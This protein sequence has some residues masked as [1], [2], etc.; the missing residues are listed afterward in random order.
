MQHWAIS[1]SIL[2]SPEF[3]YQIRAKIRTSTLGMTA[4]VQA[5]TR[6]GHKLK[7]ACDIKEVVTELE[8]KSAWEVVHGWGPAIPVRTRVYPAPPRGATTDSFVIFL[9]IPAHP[10]VN[11]S[12]GAITAHF[13][14][15]H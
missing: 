1:S 6:L 14:E 9:E 12:S 5:I 2:N 4:H 8:W 11:L 3:Y 15:G 10:Q 13:P 7:K